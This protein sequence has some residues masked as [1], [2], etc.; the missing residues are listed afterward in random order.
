MKFIL[1]KT[2]VV[3]IMA[4]TLQS[5]FVAKDYV[6]PEL[7]ETEHLYRTDNLPKDS[8]SMADVSWK[9]M[10]TDAHLKEYIDEG[11]QNNLDIRVA[12][13]QMAAAEAYM[14]QGKAGYLPTLSVGAKA[15]HQELAKN[16]Q[17]GSFFNGSIDQ[18]EITGNLSWEAD[19]WGK[20]RSN[21]RAGKAA[22][23]QS[24]AAHQAVKT[25]LVSAIATTYYQLVALD[26]Q[27]EITEQTI[28]TR[29]SSVNTIKALKEAGQVN[30]VAV[31][32]N[33]AQ[34]NNAKALKVDLEASIFKTENALNL[35]LGRTSVVVKRSKLS[36]QELDVTIKLGVPTILLRNRPD[37]MAAEYGLI[38]A[39]EMT[40]VAKS[41]FYPSLTL[42]ATGGF[43]SLDLD[44]L[45]STN[46]LFANIIG[47]LTQPI[48]N[49]RKIKT[50]HDVA[51]AQQEQAL[52]SFKKTLLTAGNE[53]SNALFDYNAETEKFEYRQ[54]EVEALRRAETNSEELL[55]NGYANY[56]DLLTARER[57]LN[58]EIN[59][60]NNKL[61]QLLSTVNIY[62]AL[63][64]G[65][66]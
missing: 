25:Q 42:T 8:I 6:R 26:A 4:T 21:K 3:V 34:Y 2:L 58:A 55:K 12:I 22:Y 52:L 14:K 15:T 41:N 10:F 19:I 35:L 36:Q 1:N 11:L 31:D 7:K 9:D 53:V 50:Q 44:E 47:G 65:W 29:E 38:N 48:F 13:Q 32:Q 62:K 60:I 28:E 56:L 51:K 54:N 30:Q 20:I 24:V 23:L 49:Q 57:V 63:G 59:V 37:V 39:F 17:F 43:Q 45:L 18:Y 5:C 33:I 66:K 64:G 61:N 16:S 46:S 40:N 27:L